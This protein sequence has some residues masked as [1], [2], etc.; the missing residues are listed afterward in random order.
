MAGATDATEARI[1]GWED[2]TEGG[3]I[4]PLNE[5]QEKTDTMAKG[6]RK[7]NLKVKNQPKKKVKAKAEANVKG[8]AVSRKTPGPLL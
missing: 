6:N 1:V 3:T 2:Q 4:A 8:G 5:S 7:A